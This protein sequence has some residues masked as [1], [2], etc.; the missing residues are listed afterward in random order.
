MDAHL[1][2]VSTKKYMSWEIHATY[3]MFLGVIPVRRPAIWCTASYIIKSI[4]EVWK[5][6]GQKQFASA[7]EVRKASLSGCNHIMLPE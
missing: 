1:Y 3:D 7:D 2:R 5:R 6:T 4:S